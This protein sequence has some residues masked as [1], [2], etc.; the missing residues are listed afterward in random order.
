MA[1]TLQLPYNVQR[2]ASPSSLEPSHT[3][4]TATATAT[5]TVAAVAVAGVTKLMKKG[6]HLSRII[7]FSPLQVHISHESLFHSQV[8]GI[9]FLHYGRPMAVPDHCPPPAPHH[10]DDR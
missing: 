1:A 6:A 3:A 5:A 9:A 8:A 2:G 7:V 10:H 4:T